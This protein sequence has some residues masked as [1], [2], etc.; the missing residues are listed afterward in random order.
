M[1]VYIALFSFL[2]FLGFV[3][4]GF[5]QEQ[6]KPETIVGKMAFKFT[7]GITNVATSIVEIPKQSYLSVRDQGGVGYV[8][9]PLKGLGMTCYRALIGTVETVFFMVPQPGYYDPMVDP[10]FVWDGWGERPQDHMRVKEAEPDE[11]ITGK[12]GE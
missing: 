8:I 1:R 7:R 11:P 5:A 3:T 10:D 6:P 2:L 4:P 12:E 9:G